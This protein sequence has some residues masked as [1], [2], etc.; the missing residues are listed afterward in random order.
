MTAANDEAELKKR[1]IFD[2]MS[3]RGRQRVLRLGYENWDP[4]QEPKD[5]REQIR[6]SLAVKVDA[7]VHQFYAAAPCNEEAKA[8]H[9]ELVE[10]CRGLL[11]EELR[12]RKIYQFCVWY[13]SV[14]NSQGRT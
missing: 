5:P 8:F 12:A 1:A 6:G 4:F 9:R 10:L 11:Q 2:G 13:G 3:K 7:L 14:A